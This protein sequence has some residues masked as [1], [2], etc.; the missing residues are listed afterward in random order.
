HGFDLLRGQLL[1]L[2]SP[3]FRT[4]PRWR[5]GLRWRYSQRGGW[6]WW[7]SRTRRGHRNPEWNRLWKER[8]D[9]AGLEHVG[10]DDDATWNISPIQLLAIGAVDQNFEYR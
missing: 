7:G 1:Y 10:N 9:I 8:V 2:R 4:K 6:P 5:R 3:V